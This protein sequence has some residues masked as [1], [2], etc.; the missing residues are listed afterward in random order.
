MSVMIKPR[1]HTVDEGRVEA[2][3]RKLQLTTMHGLDRAFAW[4]LL[5]Q[6]VNMLA[7]ALWFTPRLAYGS[8]ALLFAALL[9]GAASIGPA[10]LAWRIPGR[11]TTRH[12]IAVG[13]AVSSSL[14]IYLTGGRIETHFHIFISLALLALYIDWT[15]LATATAL[16]FADLAVRGTFWPATIFGVVQVQPWR[17]V[18]HASWLLFADF[19]FTASC[20]IRVKR[21]RFIA[22]HELHNDDLL[23]QAYT[24]TLTE[25]PNRLFFQIEIS[26]RLQRALT[27]KS[28][29]SL[30]YIDLDGF[31]TVNDTMGHAA[32]DRVLCEVASRLAAV[33]GSSTLVARL[34]GDEFVAALPENTDEAAACSLAGRLLSALLSPAY[35][36]SERAYLG[37]S[38]GVSCFPLH[39]QSLDALLQAAD[40]AMYRVKAEGRCGYALPSGPVILHG[41][42]PGA[43]TDGSSPIE[44]QLTIPVALA[45]YPALSSSSALMSPP[46]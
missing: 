40:A 30:L 46:C 14:L 9:G 21:L 2:A 41:R 31:K 27:A 11:S 17:A 37:A 4:L 29:F 24:D 35:I 16:S 36:G 8:H 10:L 5:F 22:E 28:P 7:L 44:R 32:G 43:V 38:I 3:T 20:L 34:G 1:S 42:N 33:L 6:W 18:E 15:L 13:Q 19:F 25:L 45:F 23:R 39:G 26:G 12:S